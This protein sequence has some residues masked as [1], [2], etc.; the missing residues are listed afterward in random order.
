MN[1]AAQVLASMPS[2]DRRFGDVHFDDVMAAH[3]RLAR[4][5]ERTPLVR[6][7]LLSRRLGAEAYV[8]LENALPS[9]SFK[10]RGALNLVVSLSD[11]ERKRGLVT[12]S[13]GNHGRSLAYAARQHSVACTV[14]VPQGNDPERQAAIAALGAAVEVTGRDFDAAWEAARRHSER[15]GAILVHPSRDPKLLAG[16]A[17]V[18]LEMLEQLAHPLDAL[19]VSVRG[20][21]LAT[22]M[23]LVFKA[24]SPHT[25]LIGVRPL[26]TVPVSPSVLAL[27]DDVIEVSETQ[28]VR[29]VRC[30]AESLQSS[31]DG[32]DAVAL[33]GALHAQRG[34]VGQRVGIVLTHGA[35]R[36]ARLEGLIHG[37]LQGPPA[38][39]AQLSQALA[40]LEY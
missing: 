8:K 21:T 26:S 18:A 3:R 22:G 34:I 16:R 37:E 12:A 19:F 7:P 6:Q 24:L 11:A 20:G 35:I 15:T 36:T 13:F 14:F 39:A 30:L 40:D 33:A 28:I 23:S 10:V 32:A 25:R 4:E 38:R 9:G 27:L 2:M 5:L 31:A 1:I 17:T 29:A